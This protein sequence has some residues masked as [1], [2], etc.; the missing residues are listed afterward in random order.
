V[1]DDDRIIG[2][3]EVGT[4][5][6]PSE[7]II[8]KGRLQPGRMHLVDIVEG[9]IIDDRELKSQVS[10]RFGIRRR[11]LVV[12]LGARNPLQYWKFIDRVVHPE[13]LGWEYRRRLESEAQAGRMAS[14]FIQ[15][16]D[17][18]IQTPTE[19]IPCS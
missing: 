9:R 3:S 6:L 10:S 15:P 18:Q 11:L 12:L 5:L 4:T 16:I 13:S 8:Q 7:K 19:Y 2:P 17:M 14:G 1:I